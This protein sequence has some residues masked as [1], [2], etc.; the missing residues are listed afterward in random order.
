MRVLLYSDVHL[1]FGK[2]KNYCEPGKYDIVL[3]AGDI[4]PGKAGI[5]WAGQAFPFPF[6]VAG[7]HEFYGRRDINEHYVEL[8]EAAKQHGVIFLQNKTAEGVLDDGFTKEK[9]RVIG[10][11]LWT[12]FALD[13]D[14][15]L[16]MMIGGR[17]MNDYRQIMD[18]K[19]HQEHSYNRDVSE[20]EP[21]P[22]GR[23]HVRVNP[24]YAFLTPESVLERHKES[25]VYI[26]SELEKPFDG[27]TIVM[28]HHAPS[29]NSINRKYL[30]S[31]YNHLYSSNL[32]ALIDHYQPDLW[33]HG[34][35]HSSNSYEIGK[36]KIRSN[37]RGY[38][39][40]GKGPDRAENDGF[41]LNYIVEI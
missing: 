26:T 17:A 23:R 10:A 18:R 33:V 5:A 12:D 22:D 1:E 40:Y 25:V 4:A 36:T 29:G 2:F 19:W 9:Y 8:E 39:G 15:T 13:K 32:D 28:T 30:G 38:I 11:T 24:D 7:N 34:H 14:Q 37:P 35:C 21:T 41:D 6:Y 27:K 3:L 31:D 20:W 16:G